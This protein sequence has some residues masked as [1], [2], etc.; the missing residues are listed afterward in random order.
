[1]TGVPAFALFHDVGLCKS[2][3]EARRVIMQGGVYVND[4]Q[5]GTFDERIGI[6]D[7]IDGVIHLR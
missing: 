1:V 3:G 7:I 6:E 5:I 2:R 4:R